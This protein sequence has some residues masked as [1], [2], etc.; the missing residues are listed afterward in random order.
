MP[1]FPPVTKISWARNARLQAAGAYR[2]FEDVIS[3]NTFERTGLADL[4]DHLRP[5]DSLAV[6]ISISVDLAGFWMDM[7]DMENARN[8][9]GIK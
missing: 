3:G 8:R 7:K 6:A 9:Q 2:K 4:F 5:G 1:A